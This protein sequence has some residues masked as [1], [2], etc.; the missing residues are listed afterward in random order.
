MQ[1]GYLLDTN[2]VWELRK[3]ERADPGVREWLDQH[4]DDELWLSV[5]T[6]GELR[7]GCELLRRRNE[8]AGDA[9]LA[10]LETVTADFADRILPVTTDVAERWA[11]LNVPDPMPVIDGLL[12][13]TAIEHDLVLVTRN[14]NNVERT[15]V[16]VENPFSG[17]A[18]ASE[19][20]DSG[21]I[22]EDTPRSGTD[23]SGD[24]PTEAA[25]QRPVRTPVDQGREASPRSRRPQPGTRGRRPA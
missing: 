25:N 14:T 23:D 9:L 15:G 7:R 10:W 12:A 1:G 24:L 19:S 16:P 4:A 8:Q 17:P 21:E 13:A 18:E 5:L 22:H 20:G 6:V 2:V 3:G 11:E